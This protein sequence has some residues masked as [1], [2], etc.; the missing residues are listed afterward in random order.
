MPE[1]PCLQGFKSVGKCKHLYYPKITTFTLVRI[2][3]WVFSFLCWCMYCLYLSNNRWTFLPREKNC[4]QVYFLTR[5]VKW[6]KNVKRWYSPTRSLKWGR[7]V[8]RLLLRYR[9]YIHQHKKEN[10]QLLIVT[11]V[12]V[13]IFG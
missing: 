8:Q 2:G 12:K 7:N 9:Q 3:N 5:S 4:S 6:G 1:V 13:V 10:T 11:K